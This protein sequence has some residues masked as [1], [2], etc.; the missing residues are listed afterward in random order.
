MPVQETATALAKGLLARLRHRGHPLLPVNAAPAGAA[1]LALSPLAH[2][3]P[4]QPLLLAAELA[5]GP[6]GLLVRDHPADFPIY[7]GRIQFRSTG[8]AMSL[9]GV[10]RRREDP[11]RHL[12]DFIVGQ[13]L[14]GFTMLDVGAHHGVFTLVVVQR[15]A[16][17]RLERQAA[18]FRARP[19]QPPAAGPQRHLQRA[20]CVRGPPYIGRPCRTPRVRTTSSASCRENSGQDLLPHR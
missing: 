18:Q 14:T 5:A 19:R 7:D 10:L 4:R 1:A 11:E 6:H 17:A 2:A 12:I 20:G 3:A 9:Q 8:S 16:G 13:V 15:A